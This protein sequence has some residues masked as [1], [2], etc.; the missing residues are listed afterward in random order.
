NTG[1]TVVSQM[2]VA[3]ALGG[4]LSSSYTYAGLRT[5]LQG[6]G[7]LGFEVVKTIDQVTGITTTSNYSQDFPTI[8]MPTSVNAVSAGGVVLSETAHALTSMTTVADAKYPFVTSNT[9][10]TRDLNNAEISTVMSQ[11]NADGIDASG[12]VTDSDHT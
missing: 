8:G 10:T 3:N 5:D 11:I 1:V 12:N 9:V 2:R 4:W 7:S 6:R